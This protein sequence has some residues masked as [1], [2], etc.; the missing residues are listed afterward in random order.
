MNDFVSARS[1][2][3]G[4]L[5]TVHIRILGGAHLDKHGPAGRL[6]RATSE[7]RSTPVKI[8]N[9]LPR[10]N[11]GLTCILSVFTCFFNQYL[12]SEA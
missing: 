10:N 11:N 7:D 5:P 12:V 3:L 1:K 4:S 9:F 6:G 2:A 8:G